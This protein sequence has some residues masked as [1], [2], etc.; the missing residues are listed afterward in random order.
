MLQFINNNPTTFWYEITIIDEPKAFLQLRD[1]VQFICLCSI[2]FCILNKETK[3]C[4]VLHCSQDPMEDV[5]GI[6]NHSFITVSKKYVK[7]WKY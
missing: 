3:K 2:T 4:W 7:L 5:I 1:N 6:N